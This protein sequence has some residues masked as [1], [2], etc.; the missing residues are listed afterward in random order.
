L[1]ERVSN[2]PNS[3]VGTGLFLNSA[4]VISLSGA[5][6]ALIAYIVAGI[7]VFFVCSSLGEMATLI[8][9]SGSFSTFGSRYVDPA[10]GLAIGWVYC[11]LYFIIL[12]I[13]LIASASFLRYWFDWISPYYIM[14]GVL[15][16]LVVINCMAVKGFGEVEY[17]LA[18]VCHL[19][20][21]YRLKF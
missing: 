2:F 18:M 20:S 21:N 16:V 15:F 14:A 10:L 3:T 12:P 5:V 4:Q 1:G 9:C 11:I 7:S 6:G 13:E 17:W 19:L 8:P